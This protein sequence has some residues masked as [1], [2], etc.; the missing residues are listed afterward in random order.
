[1]LTIKQTQ[2]RFM[3]NRLIQKLKNEPYWTISDDRKRPLDAHSLKSAEWKLASMKNGHWPLISLSEIN[4]DGRYEFTNRAYRLHAAD[5]RVICIDMEK[6]ADPELREALKNFP[7][8]YAE[9]SMSGNGMHYLLEVP[10]DLIPE[11]AKYLFDDMVVVKSDDSSF[12]V[13]FNNHYV[14]LT[15][16]MLP[17]SEY[18][19]KRTDEEPSHRE[20]I[21]NMLRR[22]AEIQNVRNRAKAEKAFV[23]TAEFT[24]LTPYE[25]YL[26][27]H[28]IERLN[29]DHLRT[30]NSP[31]K[32]LSDFQSDHS[33]Y[34]LYLASSIA[35]RI[36][37]MHNNLNKLL[38][39]DA[40]EM[41]KNYASK[42]VVD[43]LR[44]DPRYE[45][46]QD[47]DIANEKTRSHLAGIVYNVLCSK[48]INE[49][50]ILQPRP[51]HR[52]TRNGRP[53]L[54]DRAVDGTG[55]TCGVTLKD[56][57]PEILQANE[58][59]QDT[60]K[61]YMESTYGAKPQKGI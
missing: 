27:E 8:D 48:E 4:K 54:M 57:Q 45:G 16:N 31:F 30:L 41:K 21:T 37:R 29:P 25:K 11:E 43:E 55:F 28:M 9:V 13:F 58:S 46:W 2:E 18:T 60:V 26:S 20:K 47:F 23:A 56:S 7:V 19:L 1:M 39:Y 53:W 38:N 5:N 6:T 12:E 10:E 50:G 24:D 3:N 15:K 52:E 40:D 14:T 35:S 22:L 59:D 32:T 61:N 51:K 34:E 36:I 42:E 33:R 44:V 49:H 17:P